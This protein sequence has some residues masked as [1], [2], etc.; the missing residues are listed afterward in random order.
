[1][2]VTFLSRDLGIFIWFYQVFWSWYFEYFIS[3]IVFAR[4][5]PTTFLSLHTFT[6]SFVSCERYSS[7]KAVLVNKWWQ[8]NILKIQSFFSCDNE[9]ATISVLMKSE[10]IYD[11]H[12]NPSGSCLNWNRKQKNSWLL[13]GGTSSIIQK[14]FT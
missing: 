10:C 2:P 4:I 8:D 5:V 11:I 12:F 9:Y 13:N 14:I 3:L 7:A 6:F 1:M